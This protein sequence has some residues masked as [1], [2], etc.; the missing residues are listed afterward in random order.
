MYNTISAITQKALRVLKEEGWRSLY[1][2]TIRKIKLHS[3]SKSPPRITSLSTVDETM[4][5]HNDVAQRWLQDNRN[6]FNNPFYILFK[7]LLSLNKQIEH[8]PPI[9]CGDYE[10]YFRKQYIVNNFPFEINFQPAIK[11]EPII[12]FI[13]EFDYTYL[14]KMIHSVY[15]SLIRFLVSLRGSINLLD[16]GTGPTCGL[17]GENY[18]FLFEQE[19]INIDSVRFVGIDA[20]HK[21]AGSIFHK[22]KYLK[23]DILSFDTLEKFDLIT[24]HHVLEHCYNWEDVFRHMSTILKP[25]GYLYL[26]F[27]RFGGFYDTAYRLMATSDHCANFDITLLQSYSKK[28]GLEMCLRDIYIDPNFRFNWICNLYPNLVDR[29]TADCFYNLC[30]SIDSKLLLGYHHYGHYVIFKKLE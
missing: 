9:S 11:T 19:K 21:P 3:L 17:Y 25:E 2:K 6:N 24:G 23:S 1:E 16:F 20:F 13:N 27:P 14:R 15:L 26:S 4:H 7:H 8:V 30:I 18:R 28:V 22:S 10:D 29:E 12:E 5:D